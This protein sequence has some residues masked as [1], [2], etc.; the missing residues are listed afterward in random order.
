MI[1]HVALFLCTLMAM[2]GVGYLAHKYVMH[3]WGWFLHRS[4][5]EEHLGA[6]E[7]NDVYLLI[8]AAAAITLI[9]LGNSG[10]DPLQ[11]IGAGVAA[12]GIIYV[13]VH[14]GV[15]HRYWPFRP[16]PRHPYLKRLYQAHLLHHAVKGRKNSVSFG[17]L[18]AP[19]LRTLKRQLRE[20]REATGREEEGRRSVW[21]GYTKYSDDR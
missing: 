9:V 12:F 4:H 6:F 10:Y 18:Y 14:D 11:W 21:R 17:F 8:L 19:S 15:V 16:R 1:T 2:E 7:T 13:V 20:S 3:G 5:H